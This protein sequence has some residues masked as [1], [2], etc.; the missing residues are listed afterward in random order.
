MNR[1][2][3]IQIE[4]ENRCLLNCRHCSSLSMRSINTNK[5]SDNEIHNFLGLFKGCTNLYFTGGE[6]LFDLG[7]LERIKR[8]NSIYPDISIGLYTCGI[9]CLKGVISPIS[10]S[11]AK[12]MKNV[13]IRECYVSIYHED[14]KIHDYITNV[15]HS[16]I[17]TVESINNLRNSGITVK[18]HLVINKYNISDLDTTVAE[19]SKLGVQEI[20][21]LRMVKTGSAEIN[22]DDIGAQYSE[23]NNAILKLFEEKYKYITKISVSGFPEVSPCR[24]FENSIKC[25]SGINLLYITYEGQVYP[26]ACIKNNQEYS[27]GKIGDLK[28]IDKYISDVFIPEFYDQCINPLKD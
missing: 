28:N 19:I 23:Q 4:I 21:I 14:A 13:G 3:E 20:R 17:T 10:T 22:W 2:Y 25:Q 6:P 15:P 7:I 11:I 1:S 8:I 5:I 26:C 27:I 9:I 18:V 16:Y 24:S 12:K